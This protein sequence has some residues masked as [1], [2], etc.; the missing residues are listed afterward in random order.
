MN[1][2]DSDGVVVETLRMA[3]R[4][5]GKGQLNLSK[6]LQATA[7]SMARSAAADGGLSDDPEAIA[8]DLRALAERLRGHGVDAG[9]CANVERGAD[10]VQQG[11]QSYIGEFPNPFVC[12]RCGT[13]SSAEPP[14]HCPRCGAH[15]LT[16]ERFAPVWWMSR[17]TSAEVVDRLA[18]NPDLFQVAAAAL[19]PDLL[20]WKPE[21]T[22]WSALDVLRHV[23]DANA[24]LAQRVDLIL[25]GDDPVLEFKAVWG[26][27]NER[28]EDSSVEAILDAY[29]AARATVVA[30]L[31]DLRVGDWARTGRHEEFGRVTLLEQASYFGAHELTHLRQLE[32][33]RR[34]AH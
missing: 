23:R 18:S 1:G 29:R 20:G 17:F 32:Q 9:L 16:F 7:T 2:N 12:R 26:W 6:L 31:R 19:G 27:T 22:A 24:V 25:G 3:I 11:E 28:K 30:S 14:E 4:A 34:A 33:L 21:G 8:R 5:E 10:L 15:G 13:F